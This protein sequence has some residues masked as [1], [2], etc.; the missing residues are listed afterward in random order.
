MKKLELQPYHLFQYRGNNYVFD[1]ESSAVVKL[2]APAYDAL[3][4]RLESATPEAI[5]SHIATTYGEETAKTVLQE[6]EWLNKRGIFRGPIHTYTDQENEAYI[7]QL[8]RMRT[9]KIELYLAEACN[10][11]CRYCY[12]NDNDALNNGLMEWETAKQSVDLVFERAGGADSIN[13]TFFGG[14]PL[15]NKPILRQVIQYSQEKGQEQGKQVRYSMTTNATLLDDEIIGYIKQY[16]FGLMISMDGP[17]EVHDHMRPM[18]NGK[19]SF[20]KAARNIK[21]LMKRRRSLTVR[22]TLSNQCLDR[23]KIV[24]FLEGF[25]FTRVAMSRCSGKSDH[26]GPYDI[27]PQEVEILGQQDD[28]FVERLFKQLDNGEPVR[29]NPWA[30]AMRNIHNKQERRMR[31]GVG[32]GCTT[33][34]IDGNLYPC[35]RYVG[36]EKYILGHVSTG[37]DRERFADY[38]RGYFETK[39]K[40]ESCWAINICGGYCPWYVSAEDG[41]FPPPED[42]WCQEVRDWLEQGIWMYDTLRERYPEYLSQIVGEEV[43]PLLR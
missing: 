17:K 4:L 15:L 28:Y 2:D 24:E 42:W 1:I 8:V 9:N 32:R 3:S 26:V 20:D 25:G 36:M 41:T 34:G 7:Q 35:H 18:A 37:I 40:C 19:G 21:R 38:L 39:K 30:T 14:E 27:G 10:L 11:R 5:N 22:C 43:E 6:L 29:F 31:C 23:I 13:I 16:N 33:V 12:V